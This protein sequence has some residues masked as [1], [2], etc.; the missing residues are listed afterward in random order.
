MLY[1]SSGHISISA[2]DTLGSNTIE[3]VPIKVASTNLY[4]LDPNSLHHRIEDL[5]V[6][7]SIKSHIT[8]RDTMLHAPSRSKPVSGLSSRRFDSFSVALS[9]LLD[10]DT[11]HPHPAIVLATFPTHI[12]S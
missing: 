12:A 7:D 3:K 1:S 5:I 10:P 8:N 2:D 9:F 6:V 4:T 11:A